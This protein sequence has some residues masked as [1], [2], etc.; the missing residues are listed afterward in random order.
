MDKLLKKDF[1]MLI[2]DLNYDILPEPINLIYFADGYA[3]YGYPVAI[4][5]CIKFLKIV[6]QKPKPTLQVNLSNMENLEYLEISQTIEKNIQFGEMSKLRTLVIKDALL[7]LDSIQL[8][9]NLPFNLENIILI[10][11]YDVIDSF[12]LMFTQIQIKSKLI[13]LP[14]SLKRI[15]FYSST[16]NE[17]LIKVV[18]NNIDNIKIPFDCKVYVDKTEILNN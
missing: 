9:T 12:K 18:K 4:D 2:K 14:M 5:K 10:T 13:N 3:Y 1:Q 6:Y 11:K 16:H 17:E 15:I 8:L 7:D